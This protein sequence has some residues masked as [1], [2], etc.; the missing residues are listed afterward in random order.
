MGNILITLGIFIFLSF[1]FLT[2]VGIILVISVPNEGFEL[3][4]IIFLIFALFGIWLMRG[5]TRK[6]KLVQRFKEYQL[7]VQHYPQIIQAD[8]ATIAKLINKQINLVEKE[9][10]HLK[11][12]NLWYNLSGSIPTADTKTKIS[13]I[14]SSCAGT[15]TI[16][17]NDVSARC[18]YCGSPLN[19]ELQKATNHNNR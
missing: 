1:I 11:Q 15:N 12:A 5:G 18:S 14:C 16:L 3:F 6:K 4:V 17:I 19:D 10:N 9:I 13:L 8:A 7:L 2:C